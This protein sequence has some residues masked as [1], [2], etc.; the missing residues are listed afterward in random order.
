MLHAFMQRIYGGARQLQH[1]CWMQRETT[2][3]LMRLIGRR[4]HDRL[5]G[6]EGAL[7]D[8]AEPK[9]ICRIAIFRSVAPTSDAGSPLHGSPYAGAVG[10]SWDAT[11]CCTGAVSTSQPFSSGSEP[12]A[13]AW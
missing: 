2:E 11:S 5:S 6:T 10:R 7:S 8:G 12:G 9:A 4:N 13:D 3:E 1:R